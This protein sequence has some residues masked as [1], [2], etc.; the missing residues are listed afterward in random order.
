[1]SKFLSTYTWSFPSDTLA[2][3]AQ[4]EFVGNYTTKEKLA[5]FKDI[6]WLSQKIL[7]Y[8]VAFDAEPDMNEYIKLEDCP[9][10]NYCKDKTCCGLIDQYMTYFEAEGYSKKII[11][12]E[13]KS[14]LFFA[15]R[16]EGGECCFLE[17][18]KCAIHYKIKPLWCKL[19]VCNLMWQLSRRKFI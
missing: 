11:G 4:R 7:P 3:F 5:Q 18:S 14:K 19:Y 6:D 10:L 9:G 2:V 1:M 8:Y 13:F 15:I 17:D 16:Q 12:K